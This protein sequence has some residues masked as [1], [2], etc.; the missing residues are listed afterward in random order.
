MKDRFFYASHAELV[1]ASSIDNKE[2]PKQACLTARLVRND[3]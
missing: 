1:S 3:K 2:I